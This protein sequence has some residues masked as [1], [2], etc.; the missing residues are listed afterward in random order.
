[1]DT[2]R[3]N[4]SLESYLNRVNKSE[5][6]DAQI[7]TEENGL[8]TLSLKTQ[9]SI[10]Y[11]LEQTLD[12]INTFSKK[13]C[14]FGLLTG[15]LDGVSDNHHLGKNLLIPLILSA[16]ASEYILREKDEV[17]N[18]IGAMGESTFR[19]GG[20]YFIGYGIIKTLSTFTK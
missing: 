19:N 9:M 15:M 7:I 6:T 5:I 11:G 2:R 17:S 18:S 20:S 16:G 1:M 8:Y 4:E 14:D 10:L 13:R 3:E 12:C